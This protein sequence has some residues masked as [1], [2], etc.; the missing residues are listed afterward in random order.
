MYPQFW[1]SRIGGTYHSAVR[2][3]FFKKVKNAS[4][5]VLSCGCVAAEKDCFTLYSCKGFVNVYDLLL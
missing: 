4:A 1:M 5:T 2:L 3:F